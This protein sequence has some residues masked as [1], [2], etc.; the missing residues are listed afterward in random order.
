MGG[1]TM[2]DRA[3]EPEVMGSRQ[4]AEE[5]AAFDN[6]AVNQ[7]F[8]ARALELAPHEG[9]VLDI[10]TGPA[11]IAILLAQRAPRLRILAI[12]LGEHMLETARSNVLEAR[13]TDR[14]EIRKA[15]AKAT[16]L[17]ALSFDDLP[18]VGLS[19]SSDRHWCLERR[20]TGGAGTPPN[21]GARS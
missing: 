5:Y 1:L 4:D 11:D 20:S 14:I 2:L 18:D 13:L 16:G 9:Y 21:A 3:L 6:T 15:D 19:R 8:V 17:P 12:D 10:G 7:A